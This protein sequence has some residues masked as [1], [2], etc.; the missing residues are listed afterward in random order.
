MSYNVGALT[1]YVEQQNYP[2]IRKSLLGAKTPTIV[3]KQTGVKGSATLNII[4]EDATFQP[5]GCGFTPTGSSTLTQR[6]ITTGFI[7]VQKKWCPTD[8]DGYYAQTQLNAGSYNDAIPFEETFMQ[9]QT[10]YINQNIETALWQGNTTSGTNNLSYFNGFLQVISSSQAFVTGSVKVSSSAGLPITASNV[11][12]I[13]DGIYTN[14]PAQVLNKPDLAIFVGFD[15]FRTYTTALKNQ[16]LFNYAVNTTSDFEITLPGTT[17][18]LIALNGLNGTNQIV[19]ARKSNLYMGVDLESD[20]TDFKLWYSQDFDEVR[21]KA[22]FRIGCQ[23]AFPQEIVY[24]YNGQ[25]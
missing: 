8:L 15:T 17:I 14:I 9:L 7:S 3:N 20:S 10:D 18:K 16:N 23:V 12:S 2:L 5:G 22:R 11:I 13:I 25:V 1:A 19:A 21:M 6:T 4:D 24:W